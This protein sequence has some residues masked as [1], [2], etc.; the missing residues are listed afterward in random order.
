MLRK[1]ATSILGLILH[2]EGA[3]LSVT[4]FRDSGQLLARL[5]FAF[6]GISVLPSLTGRGRGRVE[7]RPERDSAPDAGGFSG[8][9][10]APTPTLPLRRGG[11]ERLLLGLA[12]LL[13]ACSTPAPSTALP[14]TAEGVE[15]NVSSFGE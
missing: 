1:T 13:T 11:G 5:A 12:L 7:S 15:A 6:L 3:S 10:S 14:V 8:V 9:P 2:H 4:E